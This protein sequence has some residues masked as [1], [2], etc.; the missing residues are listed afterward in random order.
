MAEAIALMPAEFKD[1]VPVTMESAGE[2]VGEQTGGFS[3]ESSNKSANGTP[4]SKWT[5]SL[6][7]T[8][9]NCMF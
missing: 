3:D 5:I 7:K 1:V 8:K 2:S 4:E 9:K 6:P